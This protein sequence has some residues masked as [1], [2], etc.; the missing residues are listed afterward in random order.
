M[1]AGHRHG[2]AAAGGRGHGAGRAADRG[3]LRW[4]LLVTVVVAAVQV[5]GGLL[6]GSLALLADA[7]HLATDA[8]AVLLALGASYLA[9]RPAGPRST[10]GWHRAEVLAAL[11]NAVVLVAVCLVLLA[12]GVRR[13]LDPVA[14][15]AAA[16]VG[17]AVVG[18]LANAVALAVLARSA[19]GSLNLRAAA[20]E[21]RADLV[22]SLLAVTAGAVVWATGWD[23]AD[24]LATLLIAALVLPRAV[25]LLR[26][27]LAVLLEVA[28][29]GLDL[30]AVERQLLAVPGVVDVHDLHAWAITSGLPSLSAHVTV[31]DV[32]LDR[33]GVGAVLDELCRCVGGTFGVKHATFQV[34]PVSHRAHEDLGDP[35]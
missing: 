20:A 18:L 23:R 7:G 32:A 4:A 13:L 15:D 10:F 14:V 24:A 21:V 30:A 9:A 8:T 16:M 22:G 5:V 19:T 34:E 17:F 26:E 11:V 31:D 33:A 2:S 28:P 25:P 6:T 12:T 3:L 35:H 27:A 1:G 29:P